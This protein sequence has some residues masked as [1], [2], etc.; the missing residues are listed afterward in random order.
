V[1]DGRAVGVLLVGWTTDLTEDD[2]RVA[3]ARAYALEATVALERADDLQLLRRAAAEDPL[4]GAANRRSLEVVLAAELPVHGEAQRAVLMVDLDDFKTYND[5]Y[6]HAAGDL[7]LKEAVAAWRT[8]LREGD[9]L[10]RYGGEEFC[11]VLRG[12]TPDEVATIAERIRA[13]TPG[14]ATVSVGSACAR[15]DEQSAELLMRADRALYRAKAAGRDRVISAEV[16]RVDGTPAR[17]S[18]G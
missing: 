18:R 7:V 4:T 13:L 12:C 17:M 8:A 15:P 6:G 14:S 9:L 10:A 3:A 16:E 5:A 2:P 11:I 1:R